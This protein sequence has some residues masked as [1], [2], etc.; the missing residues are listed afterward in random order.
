M[1]KS[2]FKKV[3]ALFPFIQALEDFFYVVFIESGYNS[4]MNSVVIDKSEIDNPSTPEQIWDVFLFELDHLFNK[5]G[6]YLSYALAT[7]CATVATHFNVY[8]LEE[9]EY[10]VFSY[11][12][13][14]FERIKKNYL[15]QLDVYLNTDARDFAT[16]KRMAREYVIESLFV[17]SKEMT[18]LMENYDFDEQSV[19]DAI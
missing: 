1:F 10:N 5:K 9:S 16:A 19:V 15:Q 13:V 6:I 14:I 3:I 12:D 18:E 4:S 11:N 8:V 17:T 7:A 2:F